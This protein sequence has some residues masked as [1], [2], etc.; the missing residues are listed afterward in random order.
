MHPAFEHILWILLMGLQS[1]SR[2]LEDS[3]LSQSVLALF[4][5]D[6]AY[7]PPCWPASGLK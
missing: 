6:E 7:P 1:T 5:V 3:N 4:R 2:H